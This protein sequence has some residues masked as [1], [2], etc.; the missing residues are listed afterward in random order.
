MTSTII[1]KVDNEN[2]VGT[3]EQRRYLDIEE[4]SMQEQL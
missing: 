4:I 2:F 1:E 3:F